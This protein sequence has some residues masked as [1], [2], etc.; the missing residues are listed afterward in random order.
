MT[1]PELQR[2]LAQMNPR[3]AQTLIFRCIDARPVDACAALYGVGIPQWEI[4]FF[5]AARAFVGQTQP[6]PD[7]QRVALAQRLQQPV[8][9]PALAPLT[10]ALAALTT[11]REEVQRLIVDTERAEA[12]SPARAREAWLRRLAVVAIIA[13]SLFV[14]MREREKPPAPSPTQ[15]PLPRPGVR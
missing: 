13:V 4:L 10:A 3:Q 14:W 1:P 12:A 8:A 11:H 15:F 2:A 7:S 5:E 9:D 6:L